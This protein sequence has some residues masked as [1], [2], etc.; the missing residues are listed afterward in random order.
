LLKYICSIKTKDDMKTKLFFTV[1]FLFFTALIFAQNTISGKVVDQKGK[2]VVGANIYIDGTY[3]GATSSETGEFSFET[4][5]TGNKFLVVS[6]LL[7]ETFKQE[8]D[9]GNYKNQTVKLRENVNA[10]DA[11]VITAGTLESGEKARVSVLK[12]L[13][14][15]TTAG[16]AG[17]I[18]A[19]LQTLPGTQTVG[20]DGRLFVRGGEASETQTFVDGIRVAQPYGATTNNLPT[21]SRFSP[22]LFSGIAFS[23]GGYS[24]EYGEALSSVLLLNTQ[25]EEDHEKT[26]IGF[27]TV[28]L[29]LGNTQKWNKS[30]LSVNMMYV[31]LAPYQAVIPQNV[32]WNNPYQ[33]LG[34]ET[35][36]RYKFTN[37]VFKLYASF[38]SERF[39][40]NQKNINFENPI[41]TDMNNNNFYLNSSYKG[42]FGTGW[43]L[44][45][46]VSYGYSKNK[47]KYDITG[48]DTQENAAQLKLKLSKKFSNYFKLSFGC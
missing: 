13:D 16:S 21:R 20:E 2:P 34:G 1:S 28:G 27:M 9:V 33:S 36:Y 25:D 10:L 44:T 40:L 15:V 11:V 43:Q 45:S 35:V 42:S 3:D 12:P 38:D 32:D 39:D 8:I 29:S 47:L 6:F 14:I 4:T 24:A 37:G 18:V 46:G 30:S 26:D 19:A 31:N 5:E 41:R 7:F 22:F 17:N 48:I 23:T